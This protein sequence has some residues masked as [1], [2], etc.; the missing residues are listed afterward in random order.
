[1]IGAKKSSLWSLFGKDSKRITSNF[2]C[3]PTVVSRTDEPMLEGTAHA[4]TKQSLQ[5]S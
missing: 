4:P 1:M 2:K 3:D 5:Q